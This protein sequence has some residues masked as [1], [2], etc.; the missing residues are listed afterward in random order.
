M[1]RFLLAFALLLVVCVPIVPATVSAE[2]DPSLLEGQIAYSYNY[3]V[4][5]KMFT[6]PPYYAPEKQIDGD[7][8]TAVDMMV[9]ENGLY[10]LTAHGIDVY[11]LK[12]GQFRETLTAKSVNYDDARGFFIT[13]DR[14]I[15]IT[16][17]EGKCVVVVNMAG[18]EVLR[19]GEPVSAQITNDFVYKPLRIAVQEN[20]LI[21]VVSEGAYDGLI[22]FDATGKFISYFG[23]N[24]VTMTGQLLLEQFWNKFRTQEQIDRTVAA[25]PTN[26]SSLC[27]N[28]DDLVYVC[29][30]DKSLETAQIKKLSP[31]GNDITAIAYSNVF[32]DV[33]P[34]GKIMNSFCDLTVDE[35]G[36]VSVLDAEKGK[37]FQYDSEN[38]LLGVF[39]AV[40]DQKGTF[41]KPIAVEHLGEKVLVLDSEGN[42][43][44]FFAPT[45]YAD[46]LRT[47]STLYQN[48]KIQ[49][50]AGYY[51]KIN[52][53]TGNLAW[54]LSGLG[55]AA[56]EKGDYKNGMRY[57]KSALDTDGYSQCFETYRS[58]I[59]GKYFWI[60]F[61][62]IAAVLVGLW[63][64]MTKATV[65]EEATVYVLQKTK[66]K[67]W[68]VLGH[69]AS[70][71]QIKEQNRGSVLY[72][73]IIFGLALLTRLF[74]LSMKGF[75]FNPEQGLKNNY[76]SEILQFVLIFACFVAC[77]WA[78]GTFIDGKGKVKELAVAYAYALTP[79]VI[80]GILAIA[81]SNV[82]TLREA[83]FVT[84]VE[85]IG[86]IWSALLVF[87]ATLQLN[88]YSFLKTIV[89]LLLTVLAL[90][91][92]LFVLI[93]L[94]TLIG[95][96]TSFLSQLLQEFQYK[97]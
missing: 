41:V 87:I 5:G 94:A 18:E 53:I 65:K 44:W 55:Q 56:L 67:P 22:Q 49:Q 25:V 72:A 6:T 66:M 95:K 51:K 33:K 76:I 42:S 75:L 60:V 64:W 77:V 16:Q 78:V 37:V 39:G 71:S 83:V 10:I 58:E 48:G 97:M 1:K 46:L 92:I 13:A 23:A 91:F 70:F 11:D 52:Q 38:H 7:F 45:E 27:L 2:T 35:N 81:M 14:K 31:Y 36:I 80:C 34:D 19:F 12:T 15:Y 61:L 43:V 4:D 89:S 8:S 68:Y 62:A 3:D 73:A 20:E 28:K 47:G 93:L 90:V 32:G 86:I 88:E 21:Y 79:Y 17:Y 30:N 29:S 82:M 74:S 9:F 24:K 63:I 69:P 59:I 26:Y 85:T 40:S 57:F 50:A 84:G 54:V 96:I